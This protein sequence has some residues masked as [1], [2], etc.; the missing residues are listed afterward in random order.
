MASVAPEQTVLPSLPT[1]VD[2]VM[3]LFGAT[4]DLAKRKLLPGLFHLYE[5]GLMPERFRIVGTSRS[6]L[7]DGEFRKLARTVI[8]MPHRASLADDRVEQFAKLL[9][10][11]KTTPG[12]AAVVGSVAV[13]REETGAEAVLHYL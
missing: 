10:Y 11:A 8:E 13:A 4:G 12:L 2:N 1:P 3:V 6:E 9:S 7:T 5:L